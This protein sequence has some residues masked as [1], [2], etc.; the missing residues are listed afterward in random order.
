MKL[1]NEVLSVFSGS[2]VNAIIYGAVALIVLF[3]IV[4]IIVAMEDFR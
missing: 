1:P 4:F 2:C 3:I